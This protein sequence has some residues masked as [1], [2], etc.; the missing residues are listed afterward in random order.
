MEGALGVVV[1]SI[2]PYSQ[3]PRGLSLPV[4]GAGI[5]LLYMSFKVILL[6]F[7]VAVATGILLAAPLLLR[8][9]TGDESP[10]PEPSV[11]GKPMGVLR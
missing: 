5:A 1:L 6:A 7:A 8:L 2:G 11:P 3:M 10:R 4:V 9:S